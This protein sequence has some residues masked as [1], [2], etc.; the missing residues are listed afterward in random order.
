ML[1]LA[2]FLQKK[3]DFCT[4]CTLF[5]FYPHQNKK[6]SLQKKNIQILALPCNRFC[7][8]H[9]LVVACW[10]NWYPCSKEGVLTMLSDFSFLMESWVSDLKLKNLFRDSKGVGI[11]AQLLQFLNLL[12][13]GWAHV[14]KFKNL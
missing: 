11:W 5:S 4:L 6:N 9:A 10:F 2:I 7:W 14:F 13:H 3:K 1:T 8:M 12:V